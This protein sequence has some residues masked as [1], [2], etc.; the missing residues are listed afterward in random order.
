MRESLV[1]RGKMILAIIVILSI[2]AGAATPALIAQDRAAEA[3]HEYSVAGIRGD[4][5]MSIT[6]EPTWRL[7]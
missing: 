4:Y 3:L 5:A 7:A 6:T 2:L 1:Q